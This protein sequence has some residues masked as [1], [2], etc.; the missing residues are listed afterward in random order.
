MANISTRII[1][2]AKGL[3]NSSFLLGFPFEAVISMLFLL[4]V[5]LLFS[6]FIE[7]ARDAKAQLPLH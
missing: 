5:I 4:S 7:T 3:G 1:I 2:T 6:S